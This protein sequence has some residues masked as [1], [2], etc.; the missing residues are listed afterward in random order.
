M[1]TT[2]TIANPAFVVL[3]GVGQQ[4]NELGHTA[5]EK[6]CSA[7]T[8]GAYYAFEV[9]SPTGMGIPPHVH[10]HEDEVIYVIEGDFEVFL[11]GTVFRAG[12]GS[13]LNFA[14]GTPHGFQNVGT[15]T[16]RTLWVVTPGASFEQFF[17]ELAQV[18]PGPPDFPMIAALFGK[19]GMDVLPPPGL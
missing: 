15:T 3:P 16:G 11:G 13:L 19:Y 9:T 12:P 18:P 6:V 1:T 4:M 14:R 17:H 5:I 8:G 2:T 10:S 7:D